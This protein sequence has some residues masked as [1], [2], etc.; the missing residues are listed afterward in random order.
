MPAGGSAPQRRK[1]LICRASR[2]PRR[3]GP[4]GLSYAGPGRRTACRV[5]SEHNARMS[6]DALA[7]RHRAIKRY[8]A[9]LA[10]GCLAI[11]LLCS[12]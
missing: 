5:G 3:L 12:E 4:F 6:R 1:P 7:R 9:S 8:L 2:P 10:C 11:L